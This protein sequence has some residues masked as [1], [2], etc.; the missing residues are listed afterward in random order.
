MTYR[1][2]PALLTVLG[3]GLAA[4]SC[5]KCTNGGDYVTK[6]DMMKIWEDG[7]TPSGGGS[8]VPGLRPF[9][10]R[11]AD[12][13]CQIESRGTYSTPLTDAKKQC[14]GGGGGTPPP[15]YPPG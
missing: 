15:K 14:P 1:Q 9:L 10:I 7:Y 5:C 11:L 4:A 6:S 3:I 8:P 2:F 13:V 12:A